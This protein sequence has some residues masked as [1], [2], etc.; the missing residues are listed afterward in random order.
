[1][2]GDRQMLPV[3]TI[4]IRPSSPTIDILSA[5]ALELGGEVTLQALADGS[6]AHHPEQPESF[7]PYIRVPALQVDVEYEDHGPDRSLAPCRRS[8]AN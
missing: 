3:H 5:H 8:H 6:H 7:S 2:N 1:M 4:R